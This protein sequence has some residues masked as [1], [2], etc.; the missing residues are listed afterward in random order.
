MDNPR[1]Q[2]GLLANIRVL[3]LTD[4]QGLFCG[5]MLGDLGADVIKVERPGGDPARHIGPFYHDNAD[6]EKSLFWWAFNTSKR[7]ITLDIETRP[8]QEI[9]KKLVRSADFV[10]ESFAP[11]FLDEVGLGYKDLEKINPRVILVS[12]S[13]FGQT[14]PHKDYKGSDIVAWATGGQMYFCGDTDRAPLRISHHSHAYL[15]AG[16]QAAIGAMMALNHRELIGQGQQVDVSIQ[17]SVILTTWSLISSWDME[18]VVIGREDTRYPATTQ[19]AVHMTRIFPCKDGFVCWIYYG[20]AIAERVG[21]PLV[22]LMEEAGMP[23]EFLKNFSWGI[24]FDPT[25]PET[26][27]QE[28]MDR[29]EAGIRPYFKAHTKAE[30][31]EEALKYGLILYPL[32][33]AEDIINNEQLAARE[34]WAKVEHPELDITLTYP[35]VIA[36]STEAPSRIWRRAP[37]IGEHNHDLYRKELGLTEAEMQDLIQEKIV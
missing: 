31:M 28:T 7:G 2:D 10:I 4:E 8:G 29:I 27:T 35:G 33:T 15:L 13:P 22:K 18:E 14:G 24:S 6:P 30:I 11:G 20:G 34:Y 32:N 19:R 36:R 3:D 25:N 9:F 21:P 37:L 12:I 5:K 16:G 26:M 1:Q 17:E 23:D